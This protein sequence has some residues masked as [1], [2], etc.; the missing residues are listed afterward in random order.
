MKENN[1]NLNQNKSFEEAFKLLEETVQKLESGGLTLEEAT[2]LFEESMEMSKLCN[3]LL[4]ATEI[5]VTKLRQAFD[6]QMRLI[7]DEESPS[8][9]Q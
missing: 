4:S 2:G 7:G 6:E 1:K 9:R 8:E 5:K 3:E